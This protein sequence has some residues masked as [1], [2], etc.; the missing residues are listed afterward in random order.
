V[1]DVPALWI[2]RELGHRSYAPVLGLHPGATA[3]GQF[4]GRNRLASLLDVHTLDFQDGVWTG[5]L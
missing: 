5:T 3:H 1:R 2:D 4:A